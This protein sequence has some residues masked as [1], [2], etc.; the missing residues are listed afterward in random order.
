MDQQIRRIEF[1]RARI[2]TL[3]KRKGSLLALSIHSK[4]PAAREAWATRLDETLEKLRR[5][6]A[7]LADLNNE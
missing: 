5:Y 7:R 2:E 6:S 3:R 1:L 4:D